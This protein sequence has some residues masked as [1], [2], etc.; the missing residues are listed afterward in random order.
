MST[1]LRSLALLAAAVVPR[2]DAQELDYQA[3]EQLFGEPVTTSV[4]GSAQRI[5]DVPAA[6]TIITADDIRRSGARDLPQVLRHVAGVDV[7]QRTNDHADVAIR[8]YN[9]AFSPRLLVLVDGRQVY[10]DYYGFTPW[11]AIPIELAAIRQIEVVRGPSSALYGFNA[12]GGVVNIVTFDPGERAGSSASVLTGTQSLLQASAVSSFDFGGGGLRVSAGHRTSDDFD[13]P[14]PAADLGTRRGD[15]RNA[16]N[17]AGRAR[18][19]DKIVGDFEGTAS[20]ADHSEIGPV[21]DGG[22]T[23]YDTSSWKARFAADTTL[24]LIAGTVYRNDMSAKIHQNT[25]RTPFIDLASDVTVARLESVAKIGAAHTLRLSAEHRDNN[26]NTSPLEGGKVFYAVSSLGAMWQWQ[27]FAAVSLTTAARVDRLDL[28]RSGVE[29]AGY[30]LRN[31]DWDRTHTETSFNVGLVW[32]VSDRDTLRFGVARGVQLPNLF[33]LGGFVLPAPPLGYVTGVPTLE[34]TVVGN[35]EAAWSRDVAALGAKLEVTAFKG[36]TRH[37]VAG[38]GGADFVAGIVGMPTNIGGSS[39]VGVE[40][41]LRA[42]REQGWRWG[43]SYTPLE[44]DDRFDPG[45]TV[46]TTLVDFEHTTPRQVVNGN[47]GW[48]RG[49]WEIDGFVR[50]ES[51]FDGIAADATVSPV[52]GRIVPIAGYATLDARLG[53]RLNDRIDLALS[54]QG[55]T[56]ARQRETSAPDVERRIFGTLEVRF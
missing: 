5:S 55:L 10:A 7:M 6:M 40:V 1:T 20:S 50:Y 15:E 11:A 19:G 47:V 4:T 26:L 48:R 37:I 24:G 38:V 41:A 49:P 52:V 2:V 51:G 36:R 30:P 3:L 42:E 45:R 12:V 33:D 13:T 53:Y 32:R 17:V 22:F 54:G 31:A 35:L 29:W 16:L 44:I 43:V 18:L 28:G 21:Y 56:H 34:P 25:S 39:A 23:D 46:A 27:R 9:Q 8:G 14:Q